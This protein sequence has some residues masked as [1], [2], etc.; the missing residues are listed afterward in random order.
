MTGDLTTE[1]VEAMAESAYATSD[2]FRT[3]AGQFPWQKL[4]GGHKAQRRTEQSS[5]LQALLSLLDARG[6]VVVPKVATLSHALEAHKIRG[7]ICR[8]SGMYEAIYAAM[9]A[10]APEPFSALAAQKESGDGR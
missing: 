3:N 6:F 7:S 8:T 4:G 5:A 10:A 9:L 2:Q 1:A